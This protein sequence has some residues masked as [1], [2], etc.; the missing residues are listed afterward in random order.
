MVLVEVFED[1]VVVVVVLVVEVVVAEQELL[2][3]LEGCCWCWRWR[4][5]SVEHCI[6]A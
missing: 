1:V 2:S 3:L 5:C 4:C 6:G